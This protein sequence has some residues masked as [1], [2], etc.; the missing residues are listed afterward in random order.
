M[1]LSA[2]KYLRVCAELGLGIC[3]GVQSKQGGGVCTGRDQ[4]GHS[5]C[6]ALVWRRCA[7]VASCL[8]TSFYSFSEKHVAR[9]GIQN[10]MVTLS[11]GHLMRQLWPLNR[12]SLETGPYYPFDN[13]PNGVNNPQVSELLVYN[14]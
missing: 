1:R 12:A 3:L 9:S 5:I 7:A 10:V 14:P 11:A 4:G 8:D 13:G 2:L 6:W